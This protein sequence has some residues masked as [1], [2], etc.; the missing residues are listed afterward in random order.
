MSVEVFH[1]GA[2]T[3]FATRSVLAHRS[4]VV[5]HFGPLLLGA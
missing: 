5:L 1:C 3:V 2:N 4:A